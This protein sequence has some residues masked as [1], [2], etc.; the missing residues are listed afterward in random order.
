MIKSCRH[1][2]IYRQHLEENISLIFHVWIIIVAIGM[3]PGEQTNRDGLAAEQERSGKKITYGKKK[4]DSNG[5]K[6]LNIR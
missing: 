1:T 4:Q 2:Y 3:S 6:T 5:M